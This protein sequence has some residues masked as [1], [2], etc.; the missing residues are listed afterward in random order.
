MLI[1][2]STY[3]VRP[4][5]VT[6]VEDPPLPPSFNCPSAPIILPPLFALTG[7]KHQREIKNA[8][9]VNV[10]VT[11]APRSDRRAQGVLHHMDKQ[12][13]EW[14]R[15]CRRT[16]N[17]DCRNLEVIKYNLA[18]CFDSSKLVQPLFFP[19]K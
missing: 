16:E 11:S 14:S 7:H 10:R 6:L 13:A 5:I 19:L 4:Y 12:S 2:P 1:I 18:F 3:F 9:V 17:V 15:I 8:Q